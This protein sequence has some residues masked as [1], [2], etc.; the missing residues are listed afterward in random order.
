MV[1]IDHIAEIRME[2]GTRHHAIR[3]SNNRRALRR[4]EIQAVV[5]GSQPCKRVT[6]KTWLSNS[7]AAAPFDCLAQF[8]QLDL[9]G[10]GFLT[11]LEG[12]DLNAG[13]YRRR[14]AADRQ[15]VE[16]TR[17]GLPSLHRYRAPRVVRS[18][19]KAA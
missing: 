7:F 2:A 11:R 4:R 10:F 6:A 12:S 15:A 17:S 1:N 13:F 9:R 19:L 18:T 14:D 5:T 8:A 3:S 16:K